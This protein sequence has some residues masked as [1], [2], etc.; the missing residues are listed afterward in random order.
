[1]KEKGR[2]GEVI[3]EENLKARIWLPWRFDEVENH[4]A[5]QTD[6][7]IQLLHLIF[8]QADQSIPRQVEAVDVATLPRQCLDFDATLDGLV[9]HEDF[10]EQLT[11]VGNHLLI[12]AA[13]LLQLGVPLKVAGQVGDKLPDL[14]EPVIH[15]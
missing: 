11:L 8:C 2:R 3:V 7:W 10:E 9:L 13:D 15:R 14:V 4:L 6:A 5:G 1:M 12:H